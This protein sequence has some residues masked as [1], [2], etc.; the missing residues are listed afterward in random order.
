MSKKEETANLP[1]VAS[2]VSQLPAEMQEAM[3]ADAGQG[4]EGASR[5][6][7]AIPFINV[8]QSLS[9]QVDKDG[10]AYV[11]GAEPGMFFNNVTG[12]IFDGKAGLL[13][14]PANFEKVY[15]E[16]VP[17]DS[18]GGWRGSYDSKDEAYEN[19]EAGN[20]IIDTA[21]HY[22]LYQDPNGDWRPAL[23]SCTSTKLKA[24]RQ[25]LSKMSQVIVDS[26]KG[27]FTPATFSQIWA[28]TT[29]KQENQKGKFYNLATEYMGLIDNPAL[30]QTVK[31]FRMS[32]DLGRGKVDYDSG[33]A[34][35][36]G[37]D[38]VKD[39]AGF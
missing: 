19:V 27:R 32:L 38:S 39:G 13:V 23:I 14:I 30:Y 15:N 29:V 37:G 22:V 26:P 17:R 33:Q 35:E 34:T 8:L 2:T 5:E 3:L 24:S 21:N 28:I 18:G 16:F 12:E 20:E 9:P 11:E 31:D 6:D 10:E 4:L 7:F 1:T 36:G 25:W